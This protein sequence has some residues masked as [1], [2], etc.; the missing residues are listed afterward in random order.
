MPVCWANGGSDACP[1]LSALS[2]A[3]HTIPINSF[4]WYS[5]YWKWVPVSLFKYTL[6]TLRTCKFF[7]NLFHHAC[8]SQSCVHAWDGGQR[9]KPNIAVHVQTPF[10]QSSLTLLGFYIGWGFMIAMEWGR[11]SSYIFCRF[12]MDVSSTYL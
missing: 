2:L 6:K 7:P 8:F 9:G 4:S 1:A 11:N 12:C 10:R 5:L 3:C